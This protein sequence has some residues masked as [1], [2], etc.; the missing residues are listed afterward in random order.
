MIGQKNLSVIDSAEQAF[1]I[2][3]Q[4]FVFFDK[5]TGTRRFEVKA[6]ADGGLPVDQVSTLLAA[7]CL[8]R[9]QSPRDFCVWVAPGD[10]LLGSLEK[11]AANLIPLC[12]LPQS[13][14]L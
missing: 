2:H 13:P 9:A 3:P 10:D 14:L 1:T 4:A 7:N 12:Q 11:H 6:N 5:K 8:M